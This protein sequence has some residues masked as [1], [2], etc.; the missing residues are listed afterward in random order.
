MIWDE[1]VDLV[2]A[3]DADFDANRSRITLWRP[4]R[5]LVLEPA[6][7]DVSGWRHWVK[8]ARRNQRTHYLVAN[9]DGYPRPLYVE[10]RPGQSVSDGLRRLAPEAV[11]ELEVN[12]GQA[13]ADGKPK[14]ED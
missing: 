13:R 12:T 10:I 9:A 5:P 11:D 8:V 7:D 3:L 14:S 2:A 4:F 6:L 1:G